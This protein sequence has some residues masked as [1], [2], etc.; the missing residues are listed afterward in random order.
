MLSVFLKAYYAIRC[1]PAP[2]YANYSLWFL[3]WKPLRKFINVVVVPCIPFNCARIL[4][5]R[6]IGFKI[7]KNVFI[8]MRC[9]MDD[10]DPS[11]TI[12]EDNITISYG[13]YFATHGKRQTHTN[14]LIRSGT[15]IGMAA[16]IISGKE[17]I[18]LGEKCVVGAGS[19]VNKSIPPGCTAVGVP[20]TVVARPGHDRQLDTEQEPNDE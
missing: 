14:I 3:F 18:T 19:L 9:Y 8:G 11:R 13:C 12:I 4:F 17:G 10:M 15:Y 5:Y 16:I 2:Y 6:A 1:K 20:A 7:G